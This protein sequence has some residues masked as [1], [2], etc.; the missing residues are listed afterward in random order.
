[1]PRSIPKANMAG[2][3]YVHGQATVLLCALGIHRELHM[4]PLRS[5][6]HSVLA[7]APRG[8]IA[9]MFAH[10]A[11]G[12][13]KTHHSE[14]AA[15]RVLVVTSYFRRFGV[16]DVFAMASV[17]HTLRIQGARYEP[18]DA[19]EPRLYARQGASWR[20]NLSEVSL[21]FD[22]RILRSILLS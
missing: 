21:Y 10:P 18:L 17:T 16:A 3:T 11:I 8:V 7:R 19:V 9:G 13:A 5:F 2:T 4:I 1:M 14:G 12:E 22:F 20:Q 15:G 6:P